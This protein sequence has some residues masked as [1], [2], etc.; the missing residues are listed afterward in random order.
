[1]NWAVVAGVQISASKVALGH[2][3]VGWSC[4]GA[5]AL[6]P[7]VQLDCW[8][9][10]R[11]GGVLLSHSASAGRLPPCTATVRADRLSRRVYRDWMRTCSPGDC[12]SLVCW[13]YVVG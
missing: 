2:M 4:F 7:R 10:G 13:S 5:A 9:Q 1:M 8:T 3:C 6:Q 12:D 11:G